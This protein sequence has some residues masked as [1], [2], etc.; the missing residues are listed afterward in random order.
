M[1]IFFSISLYM[2]RAVRVSKYGWSIEI[3]VIRVV[4]NTFVPWTRSH[5]YVIWRLVMRVKFPRSAF[6]SMDGHT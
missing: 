3:I 1:D 4:I 6:R 2:M 5:R